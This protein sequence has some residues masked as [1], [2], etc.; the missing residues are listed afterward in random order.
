[1]RT[2]LS[3]ILLFRL[4]SVFPQ[5]QRPGGVK[6]SVVWNITELSGAGQARWKS[7]ID[8]GTS[9]TLI[10]GGR[11]MINNHPA[12]LFG[13]NTQSKTLTMNLADLKTFSLFTVCQ[14]TDSITEQVIFSLDNDSLTQLVFSNY[15]MADLDLYRYYNYKTNSDITPKIYSYSQNQSDSSVTHT[16]RLLFGRPPHRDNLPVSVYK[17]IV[18]EVILFNR[19][20]SPVERRRVESY[21][22]LKYGIS[23]RQDLPASYLNSSGDVIWDARTNAD[24]NRHIAGL[25]RD[26]LSGFDQNSSESTESPGV[27]QFST[28]DSF[29]NKSFL[30]WGDNNKPLRFED[31]PGIRK[32]DRE[33][34]ISSCK[35]NNMDFKVQ[36]NELM[37]SQI[38]PLKNGEMYWLMI[39]KTG[40]GNFPFGQNTYVKSNPI[41]HG[42]RSIIFSPVEFDSDSSGNDV[43][44]LLIAPSFFTRSL[45]VPSNC[46]DIYSG[47]IHTEI[48]GG[49]GPYKMLL[50]STATREKTE[51]VVE[52][53]NTHIFNGL[54]QGGYMLYVTDADDHHFYGFRTHMRGK[55][56]FK[57]T[58]GSE[59]GRS[60]Y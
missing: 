28:S 55:H 18:P 33:W 6:G 32:L 38:N 23:L 30:I 20:L 36:T 17:G 15:R 53:A 16:D 1:M 8:P 9:E 26:D 3:L 27:L 11:A 25:G 5:E 21:L 31:K 52:S 42:N 29:T 35:S 57:L 50:V 14:E 47:A 51:T 24:Y 46:S 45:V 60:S 49:K 37:F 39:D 43:F 40:S 12:I 4:M 34:R 2:I 48:V 41:P 7:N 59:K 10:S 54:S 56:Q 19:Y 58:T 22:A 13:K 44:T